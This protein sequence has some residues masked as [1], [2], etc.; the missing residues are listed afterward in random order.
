VLQ[1][2]VDTVSSYLNAAED[3]YLCF[4]CP[5]Y[6]FSERK[7]SVRNKKYY[8]I[9]PAMRHAVITKTGN[10][11]G[12][13]LE[14]LVYL[15]LRRCFKQVYYWK[16]TSEVDFV[17]ESKHGLVPIQVSLDQPKQ[18]HEV[19]LE[20]F[21]QEFKSPANPVFINQETFEDGLWLDEI[22]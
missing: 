16:K 18:R 19:A 22:G 10:D 11:L 1:I 6:A 9:D 13:D 2:S 7:Q 3:A 17:V 20:E 4:A 5:F 12:K 21:Y 15:E 8:A 14:N